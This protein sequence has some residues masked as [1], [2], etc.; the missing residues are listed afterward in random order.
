[1]KQS[2]SDIRVGKKYPGFEEV[3]DIRK[4]GYLFRSKS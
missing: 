4:A 1:M 3:L 2:A